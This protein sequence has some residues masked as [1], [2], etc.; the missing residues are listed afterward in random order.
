MSMNELRI[1]QEKKYQDKLSL[2]FSHTIEMLKNLQQILDKNK[3][4]F[5]SLITQMV[6]KNLSERIE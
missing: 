1:E 6:N 5:L 3:I 4:P 2:P